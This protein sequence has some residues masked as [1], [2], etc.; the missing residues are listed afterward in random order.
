MQMSDLANSLANFAAYFAPYLLHLL[1]PT[2][3]ILF[4]FNK[5]ISPSTYS[6]L[7]G[8]LIVCSLFG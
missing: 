4:L 2:I 1:A 6:F 7:G 5:F 8:C 3:A